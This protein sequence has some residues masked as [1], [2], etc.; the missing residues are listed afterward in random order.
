MHYNIIVWNC[1]NYT[2][3]KHIMKTDIYKFRKDEHELGNCLDAARRVAAYNGLDKKSTLRLELLTEE[4]VGMLPNLLKYGDGEFW[5]ENKG[6]CYE[7]H[8]VV[9]ADSLLSSDKREKILDVSSSGKNSAS[10][11]IMNKIRIAAEIMLANYALTASVTTSAYPDS[12]YSFYD[13]GCYA[14]PT[15]YSNAW[16][17]SNYRSGTKE[18][19]KEWD[20]LEKSIIAKLADDVIVGIIGEKVEIVIKKKF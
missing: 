3:R 11:G 17:L 8:S 9:D 15:G 7:I 20:E 16:S 18:E 19:T 12:P 6:D 4:L 1:H 5:I 13:V 14:D 10:V 2:E